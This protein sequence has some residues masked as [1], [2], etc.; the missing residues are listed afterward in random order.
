VTDYPDDNLNN[1]ELVDVIAEREQWSKRDHDLFNRWRNTINS[2][3]PVKHAFLI[4]SPGQPPDLDR[5][6]AV[7]TYAWTTRIYLDRSN[8]K[9]I[10]DAVGRL[11]ASLDPNF[12]G[13][14]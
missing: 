13:S 12:A 5:V 2:V 4:R 8:P 14:G 9:P 6:D 1:D 10:L 7:G 3:D 11:A